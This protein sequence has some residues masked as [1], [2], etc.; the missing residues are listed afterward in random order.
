M[1]EKRRYKRHAIDIYLSIEELYQPM[2]KMKIDKSLIR[3]CNVSKGGVGFTT[4]TL[5]PLGYYVKINLRV[6]DNQIRLCTVAKIL[7]SQLMPDD[8]YYYGCEFVGLAPIYENIIE[9]LSI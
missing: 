4:K 2:Q 1:Y 6:G 9:T 7:H 8:K 3:V 5:L